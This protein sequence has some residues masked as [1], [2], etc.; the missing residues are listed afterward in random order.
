VFRQPLA[1]LKPGEL[2]ARSAETAE[3]VQELRVDN[4][5][6]KSLQGAVAAVSGSEPSVIEVNAGV[7]ARPAAEMCEEAHGVIERNYRFVASEFEG[8]AEEEVG[9][10]AEEGRFGAG[11]L[12]RT[13]VD[14]CGV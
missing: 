2:P 3:Y 4:E 12:L 13:G 6:L 10:E 1:E 7:M 11:G 8:G 14:T 5:G 9:E